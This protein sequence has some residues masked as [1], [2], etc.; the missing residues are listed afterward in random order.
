M[1]EYGI[2]DLRGQS[3]ETCIQRMICIADSRFQEGLRAQA[4]ANRKLSPDWQVPEAFRHNTPEMVAQRL[5]HARSQGYFPAF[6]FGEDFT[7]QE[8]T[9]IQALKWLKTHTRNKYAIL[10]TII[11][12]IWVRPAQ[13]EQSHLALMKLDKPHNFKEKLSAKLLVLA[14]RHTRT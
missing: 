10:T 4:V 13:A 5:A 14:L 6:P 3:D 11:K 2:A 12:A 9:I 7:S 8:K 1:T